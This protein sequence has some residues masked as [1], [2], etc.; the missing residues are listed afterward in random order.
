MLK[1]YFRIRDLY[2]HTQQ[3]KQTATLNQQ[4]VLRD[5]N[6]VHDKTYKQYM[7]SIYKKNELN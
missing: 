2:K 5:Y 4:K 6:R 3:L 1:N 7:L